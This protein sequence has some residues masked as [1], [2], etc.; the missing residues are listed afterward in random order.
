MLSRI[1]LSA[2]FAASVHAAAR[3]A[4]APQPEAVVVG[5]V[6]DSAGLAL[7]DV[8]VTLLGIGNSMRTDGAGHFRLIAPPGLVTLRA[9]RLGFAPATKQVKSQPAEDATPISLVMLRLPSFLRPVLVKS[10][11]VKYT[12]RLAGYYQRLEKK[13]GGY[14]ISREQIDRENPKSLTQLLTRIP[15]IRQTGMFAGGSSV[16][17][18]GR[19]CW[20][21][22]WL[23]GLPMNAGET[24]LDAFA[25][26][27]LQGIEL[28][29]G[30]TTAPAKYIGL[31]DESSCGTILLWS[32]GP[33]TDPP[34]SP[35]RRF[36]LE[37]MVA[38]LKVYTP[39]QVDEP[40]SIDPAHPVEIDY[41]Q[42]VF[43]TNGE[44]SVI[45]EFVVDADGRVEEETFGIV[46]SSDGQLS[47]AVR[48]AVL[49]EVFRPA[50]LKGVPVRQVV[51]Q[52]FSFSKK[53]RKG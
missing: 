41:P 38:S 31:R 35:R 27:T 50:K 17:M 15:G 37:S 23:D 9:K 42:A 16:R 20:P 53:G 29:L 39:D 52:P 48:R 7:A 45:A 49:E 40:A 44:G 32:R 1:L 34:V 33:D 22:V 36:D 18:R 46:S 4:V 30:S 24:D 11:H 13:N 5:Q 2:L 3:P 6:V 10:S 14:F 8:E 51:Q 43:A 28:Y 47:D 26:S 12:G 19:Q 25:P 21:I